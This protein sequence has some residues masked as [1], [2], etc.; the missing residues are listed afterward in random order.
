M[1]SVERYNAWIHSRI[2][3]FLGRRVLEV[4]CG[5]GNMT[6][7]LLDREIVVAVDR[8]PE[9]VS[10]V[11]GLYGGSSNLRAIA[12]DICDLDVLSQVRRFS[13]DTAVCI[14]VL[15]HIQDD[16]VA[17]RRMAQAV[18]VGG[19][20]VILAPAG[21]YLYGSLDIGLGHYR[22]YRL[23]DLVQKLESA[24]CRI[25][26]ACHMN[27]A[28]VLGWLL[29]SRVLRR[30]LLPKNMLSAFNFLAPVFDSVE[31]VFKPPVGLSALVVA[32][33]VPSWGERQKDRHDSALG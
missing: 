3:P 14:N 1:A 19:R 29:N 33:V 13:V 15:E 12:G 31:Q 11:K 24:H 22:R 6:G 7:Y 9:S 10:A 23:S 21:E 2:S 16:A 32:E 30:K 28:G 4:G 5:L 26:T 27:A 25:E 20:I 17:L 18:G 8:L